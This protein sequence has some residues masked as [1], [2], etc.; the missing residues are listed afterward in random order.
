MNKRVSPTNKA[1]SIDRLGIRHLPDACDRLMAGRM[2]VVICELFDHTRAVIQHVSS[3]DRKIVVICHNSPQKLLLGEDPLQ[4]QFAQR[5][6][7]NS[8]ALY[9]LQ[10]APSK[11]VSK[12]SLSKVKTFINELCYYVKDKNALLILE[13]GSQMLGVE[14]GANIGKYI[15]LWQ[16]YMAKQNNT[17]LF[18]MSGIGSNPITLNNI[19]L[20]QD[21][22]AGMSNLISSDGTAKL[23]IQH[24][25]S[26]GGICADQ[27]FNLVKDEN[28]FLQAQ[29]S[30]ITLDNQTQ[31]K[32]P[33]VDIESVWTLGIVV[34]GEDCPQAWSISK[35]LAQLDEVSISAVSGT[36]IL[37][38]LQTTKI[39]ILARHVF[40]LR[41]SRGNR[42]KIII[43]ELSAR[44]RHSEEKM[45]RFLGASM[46]APIEVGFS[47]LLGIIDS[48]TDLE[49]DGELSDSFEQ[50][51]VLANPERKLGYLSPR[52]FV[53]HVNDMIIQT[54]SFGIKFAFVKLN[55]YRAMNVR[56]V[57]KICQIRRPGDICTADKKSVYLFLFGCRE[58]D[59]AKA[60][61]FVFNMPVGQLFDSEERNTTIDET[62]LALEVIENQLARGALKDH[63]QWLKAHYAKGSTKGPGATVFDYRKT[64]P[65]VSNQ[66]A[67]EAIAKPLRVK[68]Q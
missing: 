36:I 66:P 10:S 25:Y 49:F 34:K 14:D 44:M 43:R 21:R 32:A 64:D 52:E 33:A 7:D 22:L 46:V 15:D 51:F 48:I 3:S 61:S 1:R 2:Y 68:I 13:N 24:W 4:R 27:Q 35:N 42:V 17:V 5:V 31:T 23:A 54:R 39:E 59:I 65:A 18:L 53:D 8:V 41:K 11:R 38:Y 57:L 62:L 30:E 26:S 9:Q 20:V 56:D 16:A 58:S 28:G 50:A 37:P 63:S 29:Q 12:A 19:R 6:N 45:I 55:V 47:R 40:A 60:L 67:T